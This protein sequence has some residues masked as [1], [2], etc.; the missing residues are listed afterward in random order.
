ML[1]LT[2]VGDWRVVVQSRDA[3]WAQRVVI[4]NAVGGPQVLDGTVGLILDVQGN[5]QT[6]WQLSIEH[7]DGSG[8][9]PNDLAPDA[10][11]I[12]GSSITQV[13]WSEDSP[14]GGDDDYNDLVVRLEKL[15]MVDQ[16]SNPFAV[17]PTAMQVMPE[18]IF[19]A[20]LG[21]YFLAVTVRNVWTQ[22]WPVQAAV[23]L[24]ARCRNWLQA[25]GVVVDEAWS[26]DDLA[27]VGQAVAGGLVQVGPLAPWAA[28][29]VYFKVDVT[30]AIVRKHNVEI[31]VLEPAAEDPDHLNRKAMAPMCV[32]RTTYDAPNG[33]FR[34]VCDRGTMTAAVKELTVDYHS[35]KRAVG[36]ARELFATSA[37]TG[38]GGAGGQQGS[39]CTPA[40]RE[41]LRRRLL[42]VLEGKDEDL[43]G[44]WRE[45]QCCCPGGEDGGD[46]DWVTPGDGAL[47][48]FAFPSLVDY[49]VDYLP[50]F[51]GQHGPIPFDD[52][53]WKILLIIIAII[54]T[55]AAV[56]SAAADL[57]NRSDDA[58]IGQVTRGILNPFKNASDIPSN[59]PSTAPGSVDATVVKLNG[60]RGQT[61]SIFS[62]R[63]ASSDE[64]NTT[65][66][67]ALGGTIDTSGLTLTNAQIDQI[68]QNL[69]DNPGDP[70]ARAAVQVF[71]SG[72]RSGT[73]I[74]LLG[75][76]VPSYPRGPEEDGSTVFFAN[77]LSILAD[78]AAPTKIS[79]GGDSGSLWLQ[80]NA[81][82]AIVALNHA[83][84]A[85]DMTAGACRIEDVMN[86]LNIRFA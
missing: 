55:L 71:K 34:S 85:D 14:G 28:T 51:T 32:S 43:C 7:N 8:W 17:W 23:G 63:D 58:V 19:E 11:V 3:A 46:G 84:S 47:A 57:A 67:V 76:V 59:L 83:S 25:G 36:R 9:V 12:S 62:Y 75:S 42:A 61:S 66:I 77:Q 53:W 4:T 45:L 86:A 52:P 44:I 81:P 54:L 38:T 1:E 37:G 39:R 65:P 60:N 30:N 13:V 33:V 31:E 70:A 40:N 56:A 26:V 16:P 20:S 15:G 18:G 24:T 48:M 78:P 10:Q 35:F 27:V 29:V 68:L 5:E 2:L 73:T 50:G 49:R 41:R 21:R 22:A 74:A 79:R 6:P 72:A 64:E 80:R 69:A 82:R